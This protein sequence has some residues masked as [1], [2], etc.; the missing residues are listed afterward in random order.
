MLFAPRR[1]SLSQLLPLGALATLAVF[2]GCGRQ[3]APAST[4]SADLSVKTLLSVADVAT[5]TAT[6]S[7]PALAA[8]RTVTLSAQNAGTWGAVVGTLPVG[9]NYVFTANANDKGGNTLYTGAATG[10]SILTGQTITVLIMAQQAT[11]PTPFQNSVPVID[12][13]FL[14]SANIVPG[15]TVTAT[16]TAHDPDSGDTLTFAWSTNPAV[17]GFSASTASTTNW[18]APATEGD[19]T[20]TVAV[21]DGHSATASA[22]VVV[23]VAVKNGTGQAAVTVSTNTWPVVTNLVAAPGY[24]A[25]G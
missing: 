5:V 3:E 12:S 7:G 4:G 23:H 22:S 18:T 15:A 19:V 1:L 17:D 20:L 8:P 6:I 2:S 25:L 16:V 13:L 9:T 11:A 24:V 21:T 14:S 10:V